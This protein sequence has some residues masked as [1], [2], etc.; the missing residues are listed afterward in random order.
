MPRQA[1]A[2]ANGARY[3]TMADYGFEFVA[4]PPLPVK[5]RTSC[6]TIVADKGLGFNAMEDMIAVAGDFI[7]LV[8]VSISTVRMH[9]RSFL[10]QK[11]KRYADADIASIVTGD[12]FET[13]VLQGQAEAYFEEVAAIGAQ[14]VEVASAQ[15]ILSLEAKVE[16]IRAASRHGLKVVAEVGQKGGEAWGA[17]PGWIQRQSDAFFS[18]GAW[19]VLVQ[20]E[21]VVEGVDEMDTKTLYDLASKYELKDLIFQAKDERSQIWLIKNFGPEVNLDVNSDHPVAIQLCRLGIRKR[22]LFGLVANVAP[23]GVDAA[24]AGTVPP[25]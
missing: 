20:G 19:K 24:R 21:G 23:I 1:R 8:K 6:L 11:I 17:H 18:A 7:D 16:L 5:P 13:A 15:I 3:G 9:R 2:S 4:V 25:A 12:L 10:V 14:G 22:G